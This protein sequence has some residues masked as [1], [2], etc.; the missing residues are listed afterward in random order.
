[1]YLDCQSILKTQCTILIIC[2]PLADEFL[3]GYGED[4]KGDDRGWFVLTNY[5]LII[6]DGVSF[7]Y[8]TIK[9]T[10]IESYKL[11]D[12]VSVPCVF[13]LKTGS[14]LKVNKVE[15]YPDE[16][17]LQFAIDLNNATMIQ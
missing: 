4:D 12:D 3:I 1:M 10:D 13:N 8:Q 14:S 5:N 6:K 11:S 9:L 16:K 7:A 15:Q 17:Y 2:K